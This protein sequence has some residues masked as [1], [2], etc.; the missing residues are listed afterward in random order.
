LSSAKAALAAEAAAQRKAE[1][2]AKS[3]K[4][5]LFF[6]LIF[7]TLGSTNRADQDFVSELGHRI[8]TLT[9]DPRENCFIFQRTS[10]ALLR[11][12]AVSVADSF[13]SHD[14]FADHPKHT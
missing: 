5:H 8:S 13:A 6:L 2:Y 11:F 14:V 7:E 3:T 12:N 4:M 10:V 1:K 9:K